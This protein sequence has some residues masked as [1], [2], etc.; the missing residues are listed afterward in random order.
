MM[1]LASCS[2]RG[3][4]CASQ[5][6]Q[7]RRLLRSV[8]EGLMEQ[9]PQ[10]DAV[11]LSGGYFVQPIKPNSYLDLS[12]EER[13]ELLREAHFAQDVMEAAQALDRRRKGALLIFGVDTAKL[14]NPM[15]DQLCVAWSA[16][17]P[18]GI[19]RKVFPTEYE[20]Q[21][22]FIVNL[23]DYGTEKR[24][25]SIGATRVLLC[26][27]YDGYGISNQPDKSGY[28]SRI[29]VSGGIFC[30]H[31]AEF[32]EF[33]HC[34][35]SN[36]RGLVGKANAAAVAIHQFGDENR[37]GF[38]TNYWRRHGIATASAKLGGGWVVAGANFAGRVPAAGVDVLAAHEVPERHLWEGQRRKAQ[39]AKPTR[40][41]LAANGAVRVRLFDFGVPG[42]NG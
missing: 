23:E 42:D 36:W 41:Y 10:V 22:G 33:L 28:V 16:E 5:N 25:V 31:D 15:G 11:V 4:P 39:D 14:K 18:V 9:Q 17:G 1:R 13:C 30:K 21:C 12:F 2:F 7:R 3:L 24:V 35:L 40:D 29:S 27:C 6:G 19:G 34:G 37:D 20:G 38:S 8:T 26:A 32:R